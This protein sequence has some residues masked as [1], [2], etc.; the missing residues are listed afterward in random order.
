MREGAGER[1][2]AQ[3][4]NRRWHLPEATLFARSRKHLRSLKRALKTGKRLSDELTFYYSPGEAACIAPADI[5]EVERVYRVVLERGGPGSRMVMEGMLTALASTGSPDSLPFWQE[6]LA[7]TGKRGMLKQL[8]HE[9]AVAGIALAAFRAGA[10]ESLAALQA[11]ATAG[12]TPMV[13]ALATRA[14]WLTPR[15]LELPEAPP[16]LPT[17]LARVAT[18]G[19]GLLPRYQARLGLHLLEQPIP[20]DAPRGSLAFKVKLGTGF[21]CIVELPSVAPLI[22]LHDAIQAGFRWDADHLYSFYLDNAHRGRAFEVHGLDPMEMPREDTEQPDVSEWRLGEL[23]FVKGSRFTYVFDF[24]DRHV[25][26]ITVAALHDAP[27]PYPLPNITRTGVPP[28]Q[29]PDYEDR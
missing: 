13:Q 2:D 11:L 10:A 6:A 21:H 19:D 27:R 28:R 12:T 14:L 22:A 7:W 20:L 1:L 9:L 24:G 5:P 29:Y 4:C 16:F 15:T 25:F 17:L 23:G 26:G 3:L 18:E 8:R